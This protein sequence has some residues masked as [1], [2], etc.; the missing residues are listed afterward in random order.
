MIRVKINNDLTI[1]HDIKYALTHI[2]QIMHI[3]YSSLE[4]LKENFKSMIEMFF[5]VSEDKK[6]IKKL[7]LIYK[8]IDDINNRR[9]FMYKYYNWL[10]SIEG[11]TTYIRERR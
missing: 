5:E 8:K 3:E 6:F 7:K 1:E 11:N 10:L 9:E 4:T 2:M